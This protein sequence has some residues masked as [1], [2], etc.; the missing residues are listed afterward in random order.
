LLTLKI[1]IKKT[2]SSDV[3]INRRDSTANRWSVPSAWCTM[4]YKED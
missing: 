3:M 2:I 1:I 4:M